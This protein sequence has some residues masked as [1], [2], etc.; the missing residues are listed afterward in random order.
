[1]ETIGHSPSNEPVH[2]TV[3]EMLGLIGVPG[4]HIDHQVVC[5]REIWKD[6]V[7]DPM[8]G[9]KKDKH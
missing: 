4:C 7:R 6:E 1:M 5:T 8:D 9:E 3:K 2:K